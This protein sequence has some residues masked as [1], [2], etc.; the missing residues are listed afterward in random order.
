MFPAEHFGPLYA[1]LT[2]PA[3]VTMWLIDPL[4][5]LILGDSDALADADFS[6]VSIGFAIICGLCL[7]QVFLPKVGLIAAAKK[8]SEEK[9]MKTESSNKIE[10]WCFLHLFIEKNIL[11]SEILL[12][13]NSF[14]KKCESDHAENI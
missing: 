10:N 8:M 9:E 4:F 1:I 14:T 7:I 12:T 11:Q 3:F 5:R 13:V 6:K 2:A